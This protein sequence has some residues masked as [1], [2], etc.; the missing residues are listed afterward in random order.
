MPKDS[1]HVIEIDIATRI[2]RDDEDM[3]VVRPGASYSLYEDFERDKSVFLDFPDLPLNLDQKPKATTTLREIIARSILLREW[4][5]GKLKS[6]PSRK[7]E[8]Y[9][10]TATGR[11]IGHY[12]GAIQRL[13]YELSVGT[14]I[15]V[16]PKSPLGNVLFAELAGP[17]QR[18]KPVRQYPGED[19]MVR[20]VRWLAQQQK[21]SLSPELR[22]A[23]ERPTPV[24]Q[25][26]RSLR[27]EVLRIA[28]KQYVFAG[29]NSARLMTSA[30]D[31]S[32]LDDLNIQLFNNYIAGLLA[33]EEAGI[34]GR[35][36]SITEA[37]QLLRERRDLVPELNQSISSPG[38]QRLYSDH[39][40]PLVIAALMTA[41][42]ASSANAQTA[43]IR[44]KN[45]AM[46]KQD[47]CAVQVEERVKG[48]MSLA[49]FDEF[50]EMCARLKQTHESTGLTTSMKAS[51][52]KKSRK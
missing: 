7:Q 8:D 47:P 3:Y 49:H 31:F 22:A 48:S 16:P 30:E 38:F 26:P 41:A 4:H 42:L 43:E 23:L 10:G 29:V 51:D 9:T 19:M 11:R 36:V 2:F 33:A 44:V 24:M 18:R 34:A 1:G 12:I 14:I 5:Q 17:T 27:D 37:L 32:T 35:P 46:L 45:S 13:Y 6:E 28:F 50:K 21:A 40:A 39:I 15:L 25:L 52:H 20:P